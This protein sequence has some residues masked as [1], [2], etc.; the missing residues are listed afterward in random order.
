MRNKAMKINSIKQSRRGFTLV[1]ILAVMFIIAILMT[2]VIG[3]FGWV[4][5]SRRE[6]AAKAFVARISA[7]LQAYQADTGELPP[8]NATLDSSNAVYQVLFGDFDGDGFPDKENGVRNTIYVEELNP[9]QQKGKEP[10][11]TMIKNKFCMVDP[12]GQ[13]YRYRLGFQQI[14][15]KGDRGTGINPDFDFW[16]VGK[17]GKDNI[18]KEKDESNSDNIGN[19]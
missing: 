3:G 11:V 15:A 4:E 9:N 10:I 5:T 1:E 12:W 13:P 7:G 14:N 8:G 19:M 2:F 16:S 6:E 17:D 18:K